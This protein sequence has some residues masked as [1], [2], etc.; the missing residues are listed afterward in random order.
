[1]EHSHTGTESPLDR[2]VLWRDNFHIPED[3]LNRVRDQILNDDA[4]F[5]GGVHSSFYNREWKTRPDY[6][7]VDYYMKAI[8]RM[9]HDLHLTH[10]DFSLEH[11]CQI[12][13]GEH[14]DHTHFDPDIF[15]SFVHFIRPMGDD[16]FQF[17]GL[18]DTYHCPKQKPGDFIVFPSWAIHRVK[19]SIGKNRMVVAGNLYI[20][21]F[22][23]ICDDDLYTLEY[24]TAKPKQLYIVERFNHGSN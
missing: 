16:N 20:N 22:E 10:H 2:L 23:N 15:M 6:A 4:C 13:D 24:T 7:L 8:M 19:S 9:A 12:Y 14:P 3:E 11:W 21:K 5:D 1:M 18:G 17:V